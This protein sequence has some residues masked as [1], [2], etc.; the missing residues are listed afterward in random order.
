MAS[1]FIG[2]HQVLA[3]KTKGVEPGK[4]LV[5]LRRDGQK[6]HWVLMDMK[7]YRQKSVLR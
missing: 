4:I 7:D 6:A 2:Y 3:V 5:K 1:K